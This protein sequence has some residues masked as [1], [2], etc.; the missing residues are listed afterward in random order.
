MD[1]C[2]TVSTGD[3]P[4]ILRMTYLSPALPPPAVTTCCPWVPQAICPASP[5]P[6]KGHALQEA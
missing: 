1:L 2:A 4:Y 5:S 3:H 6:C